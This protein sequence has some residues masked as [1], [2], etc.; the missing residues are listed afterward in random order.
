M[1]ENA[2]END[3]NQSKFYRVVSTE[4]ITD[5]NELFDALSNFLMKD[6]KRQLSAGYLDEKDQIASRLTW[7]SFLLLKDWQFF[8]A[9]DGMFLVEIILTHFS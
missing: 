8:F 7:V 3:A 4:A 9:F 1:S 5:S 2:E 6:K